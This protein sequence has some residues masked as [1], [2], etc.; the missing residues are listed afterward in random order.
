MIATGSKVCTLEQAI[1][2]RRAQTAPVVF[3]NGVFDLLHRGHVESLEAAR[4]LGGAL[5]VGV[6]GD[7]S[8][9]ALGKG[10][11]RPVTSAGDRARVVAGLAAVDRVVIFEEDTPLVVLAALRPDLLVKGGDYT[12]D[13]VVGADLVASWGGRV[14]TVPFV[15]GYSSSQILER[16]RDPT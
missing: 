5:V 13:T 6:N 14:V 12:P 11:D 16:L 15:T 4:A 3:S 10:F 7:R 2:W 1:A 8:A 9:R